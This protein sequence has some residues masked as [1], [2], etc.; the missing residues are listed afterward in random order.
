MVYA[1]GV[2]KP[3]CFRH[4]KDT[5]FK[6]TRKTPSFLMPTLNFEKSDL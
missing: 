3:A 6:A 5:I 2:R 1:G 4:N